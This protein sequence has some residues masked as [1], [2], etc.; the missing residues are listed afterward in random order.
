MRIDDQDRIFIR[1][2]WLGDA[3]I[4]PERARLIEANPGLKKY[5]D[6]AAMGTAVHTAIEEVLNENCD[7]NQISERAVEA[8]AE[9]RAELALTG[10]QLNVT[11]TDPAK[12]DTH[13]ASMAGAWLRDISPHVPR[14]GLSEFKFEV[15]V[16]EVEKLHPNPENERPFHDLYFEGTM[17]YLAPD[18]SAWDWKTAA[19]KYSLNE[20]QS[21]N[22]QSAVYACAVHND[23]ASHGFPVTDP[24]NFRFGVMIRNASST[25]QIVTV[26]RDAGHRKW[27]VEQATAMANTVLALQ[28][29]LS[30]KQRW[31]VND[32]HFLCSERW[33]PVWSLCKGKFIQDSSAI[34]E[35]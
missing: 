3:L 32:Q 30:A 22:I 33:C 21:Q 1:Q 27:I 5:N 15:R 25:G 20:K 7:P 17:D 29:S 34:S 18:G 19:R 4:C 23:P 11:N 9:L 28:K 31:M 6:S 12:W 16:G 8:F 2:S 10:E 35:E 13:V 24:L 14:G 26:T